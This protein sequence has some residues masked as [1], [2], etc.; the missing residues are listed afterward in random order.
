MA[1][2]PQPSHSH[3]ADRAG[4]KAPLLVN[5]ARL[6]GKRLD[7][8][9]SYEPYLAYPDKVYEL[10]EMRIAAKRLRYTM[11]IFQDA[12]ALRPDVGA[13]FGQALD[14]VKAVQEHL[15]ALHDADVLVPRLLEHLAH[16]LRDGY[17]TPPHEAH[18]VT[19]HADA[20]KKT[21]SLPAKPLLLASPDTDGRPIAGVHRVNYDACQGLLNLCT[22]TRADRDARY[23]LLQQAWQEMAQARQFDRLRHLLAER[24]LEEE[25]GANT[26]TMPAAPS[27]ASGKGRDDAAGAANS[28]AGADTLN[29]M[30]DAAGAEK[31]AAQKA[32]KGAALSAPTSSIVSSSAKEPDAENAANR[33]SPQVQRAPGE[34]GHVAAARRRATTER[35][36]KTEPAAGEDRKAA[37]GKSK[38]EGDGGTFVLRNGQ[39]ESR[40]DRSGPARNKADRGKRAGRKNDAARS[41]ARRDD[42]SRPPRP[43]R[44]RPDTHKG[45]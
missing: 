1:K 43:A 21:Q 28:G 10:H 38:A 14:A 7:A 25:K 11:E 24:S 18:H 33:Q 32:K 45:A 39:P 9:L 16:I 41:A 44:S 19:A 20:A 27:P 42:A 30:E 34:P 40:A 2:T 13:Q 17:G 6:I 8:F 35:G 12:Y 22:Q 23:A 29:T 36:R 15:G 31:G 37:S 26:G 5:A 4:A 3:R